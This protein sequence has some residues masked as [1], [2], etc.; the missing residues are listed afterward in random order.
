MSNA[1]IANHPVNPSKYSPQELKSFVDGVIAASSLMRREYET[2]AIDCAKS[3]RNFGFPHY[4]V[5]LH[6]CLPLFDILNIVDAMVDTDKAV[7]FPGSSRIKD[8]REVL[9][10]CFENFL[11]EKDE[12]TGDVTPLFSLDEVVGGHS[13]E[14][15][16]RSYETGVRRLA[17]HR[18]R[19]SERRMSDVDEWVYDLK[20]KFPL[21]V[22]GLRDMR[23]P[24]RKMSWEY[25]KR[26]EDGEI[27]EIPVKKIITMDD[28][29]YESVRFAHPV[30][31]GWQASEGFF[32]RIEEVTRTRVYENFL[33]D[34]ARYMGADP[35]RINLERSRLISDCEKYSRK[36]EHH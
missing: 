17:S 3:H 4:I 34:V 25:L 6:G 16:I 7:Y 8:S 13:V 12:E 15:L 31:K 19:G 18:L 33:K 14:R 30:S 1:D 2:L 9:R 10:R 29:D 22:F 35:D 27:F 11:R 5:S 23:N 26:V 21:R 32:P 28:P 24:N 20:Q 36:P